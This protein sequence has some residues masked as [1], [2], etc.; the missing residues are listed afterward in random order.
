MKTLNKFYLLSKNILTGEKYYNYKTKSLILNKM[1]SHFIFDTDQNIFFLK[2]ALKLT[3]DTVKNR[4]KILFY[5][6]V[7]AYYSYNLEIL[8]KI[9]KNNKNVYLTTERWVTGSLSNYKVKKSY[10]INKLPSLVIIINNTV[11]ETL[12]I[13]NEASVLSIPAIVLVSSDFKFDLITY[14]IWGNTYSINSIYF[15][16]ILFS[17]SVFYG[18]CREKFLFKI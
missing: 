3:S 2:K 10:P 8:K 1:N 11:T 4:N 5:F 7:L 17:N 13:L 16:I 6:P 15:L 18:S 14:P 9:L 12:N